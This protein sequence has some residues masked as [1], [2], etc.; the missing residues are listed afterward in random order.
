M[1]GGGLPTKDKKGVWPAAKVWR[2]FSE[3]SEGAK[4]TSEQHE[5]LKGH[6][7]WIWK[8]GT[9]E[10]TLGIMDKGE[11]VIQQ[12]EQD[13]PTLDAP[14]MGVRFPAVAEFLGWLGK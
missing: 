6:G 4:I 3:D 8:E 14:S 13:L 5:K 11:D 2:L 10:D 7:I 12:L 9:I 1:Y